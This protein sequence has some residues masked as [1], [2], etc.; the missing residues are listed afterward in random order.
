[1]CLDILAPCV[2]SGCAS[3]F[4]VCGLPRIL[5]A[6]LDYLGQ[7]TMD[8]S[9]LGLH[10][11]LCSHGLCVTVQV[12]LL[13]ID[14]PCLSSVSSLDY[15]SVSSWDYGFTGARGLR[16]RT[17]FLRAAVLWCSFS[18]LPRVSSEGSIDFAHSFQVAGA[19]ESHAVDVVLVSSCTHFLVWGLFIIFFPILIFCNGF[20]FILGQPWK[21]VNLCEFPLHTGPLRQIFL[22]S[23]GSVLQVLDSAHSWL[24]YL[25]R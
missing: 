16:D 8:L 17:E 14:P 24:I 20:P 25:H 10:L 19:L 12:D 5:C 22:I 15:G 6:S 9:V 4:T 2:F 23:P 3:S 7:V 1:M 11:Y 13:A 18:R 21:F